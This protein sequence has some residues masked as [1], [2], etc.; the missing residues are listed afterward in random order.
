MG[1]LVYYEE[2]GVGDQAVHFFGNPHRCELVELAGDDERRD[3]DFVKDVFRRVI[4]GALEEGREEEGIDM[5]EMVDVSI[6]V[7]AIHHPGVHDLEQSPHPKRKRILEEKMA[8]QVALLG[9]RRPQQMGDLKEIAGEAHIVEI[10][11]RMAVSPE[12]ENHR[13]DPL[14][15]AAIKFEDRLHPQAMTDQDRLFEFECVE[16]RLAVLDQGIEGELFG[17]LL[18]LGSSMS[19]IVPSDELV[20]RSKCL[21]EIA[22]KKGPDPQAVAA[23]DRRFPTTGRLIG[24]PCPVERLDDPFP[25]C[26]QDGEFPSFDFFLRRGHRGCSL[27]ENSPKKQDDPF[28]P[29]QGEPPPQSHRS[30]A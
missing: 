5:E 25:V 28:G 23:D 30:S 17:V 9:K 13:G 11:H 15:P 1:R 14:R 2:F 10:I 26:S 21:L 18:E 3:F 27:D 22:P 20:G 7:F 16:D 24:E 4:L 29:R 19:P 12:T 6:G 8:D